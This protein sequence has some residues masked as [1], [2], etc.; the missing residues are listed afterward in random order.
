MGGLHIRQTWEA[1]LDKLKLQTTK[2]TFDTWF[3]HTEI[4]KQEG[5]TYTIGVKN[6]Y[7]KDWLE[8]RFSTKINHALA[9]VVNSPV[10]LLFIILDDSEGSKALGSINHQQPATTPTLS[11]NVVLQTSES[12][13]KNSLNG[14]ANGGFNL[15]GDV[16]LSNNNTFGRF[17]VGSSNRLA[18]AA[19]RAV[20]ERP[21]E[22]YNPLFLYG[23][24]GLGKTHL[25]QAIAHEA[26]KNSQKVI[27]V[28]S[29]T[30]TNDFINAIRQQATD[31]FREHYRNTDFL[32]VDDIQFIAG[33]ESTQEEFFHT[34]NDIHSVG[35]Q[36]VL[37]SDRLPKA[38]HPLEERL[39]S[40]F[41]WGLSADLQPP[42]LETRLAILRFKADEINMMVPN[43]VMD[44]IAGRCQN[45]IRE[46]EGAL[47][48]VIAHAA[49]NEEL[50]TLEQAKY[51]LQD[52]VT[53]Q[54]SITIDMVID[55][56]TEYFG[57][58][59]EEMKGNGRSKRVA[60][61]RQMVMYL[62]RE[63]TKASLPQIGD[64]LGGRDHTTIMYG[65]DKV[66]KLVEENEVTRRD[67]M[68]IREI[69]YQ[70]VY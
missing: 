35:G 11:N 65:C 21:G 5:C 40:R 67:A 24:V 49:L 37:T 56:V 63:E 66:A 46:L 53:R 19:S 22:A 32:L 41:E 38:I 26:L 4:V 59:V 61:P 25:L 15:G 13:M 36:I 69:L 68:K 31:A 44:F 12:T 48:K 57:L 70:K 9:Q 14:M 7:V 3:K 50:I 23:G 47:N 33:K 62:A 1:T 42:D 51:A 39:T 6:G 18:H 17:V 54:A 45:N 43:D 20:A 60:A 29:E 52:L 55:A 2:A 27:Y 34:F 64:S 10:E 28:S 30:F 8:N 16:K 58:T